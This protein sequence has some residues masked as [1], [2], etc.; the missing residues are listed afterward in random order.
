[1][2]VKENSIKHNIT[3]ACVDTNLRINMQ[4]YEYSIDSL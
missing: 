4:K 2:K 1:M 3:V